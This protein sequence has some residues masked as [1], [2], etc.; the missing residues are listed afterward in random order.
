MYT[1]EKFQ[2]LSELRKAE[3]LL[4]TLSDLE[5]HWDQNPSLDK[6]KTYMNWLDK[7][8]NFY[9]LQSLS[10]ALNSNSKMRQLMD[11]AVPIE[12]FLNK[13]KYDFEFLVSNEDNNNIQ[14]KVLPIYVVL[15]H[16]RS[17][18]KVRSIFRSAECLGVKHIFL[19]G[20]T[21]T[22]LEKNVQKT[23]MGT[24]K[25]V[26]WSQHEH[27]EDVFSKLQAQEIVPV[28]LETVENAIPVE[29]FQCPKQVAILLGNERFGL[30]TSALKIADSIVKIPMLG[31][32]NS[33][34]VVSAFSLAAYE[35]SKQF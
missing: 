14:R 31:V 15:D 1:K 21:P 32:K 33:L 29:K 22:P 4:Q 20:Y 11:I 5:I 23:A 7:S 17:A 34:N 25:W 18:F 24:E 9:R 8:S 2:S 6:L 28:A 10:S 35:M 26:S 30:S 16:L 13:S 19:V 12:R 27:M 3:V